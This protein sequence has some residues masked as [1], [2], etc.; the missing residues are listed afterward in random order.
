[1]CCSSCLP[2][3]SGTGPFYYDTYTV[4]NPGG[5]TCVTIVLDAMTCTGTPFIHASAYM[6]SFDPN[7]LGTNYLGDIG[8]SP[9]PSTNPKTFSVTLPAG[10]ALVVVVNAVTSGAGGACAGYSVTVTGLGSCPTPVPTTP[11]SNT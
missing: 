2:C 10:Q 8:A 6:T 1:M 3:T 5:S 4:A 7:N 9:D 11:P